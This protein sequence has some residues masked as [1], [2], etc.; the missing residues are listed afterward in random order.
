VY[1]NLKTNISFVDFIYLL[2]TETNIEPEELRI[3]I[4]LNKFSKFGKN[5]KLLNILEVF[6]RLATRKQIKVTDL[7]K[8]EINEILLEKYSNKKTEKL[9]KELDMIGY[10]KETTKHFK[11][12]EID[13]VKQIKFE[14]DKLGKAEYTNPKAPKNFYIVLDV[15]T[16]EY[17]GRATLRQICSGDEEK[18]IFKTKD[19]YKYEPFQ[20]YNRLL[21][22]KHKFVP[23]TLTIRGERV[24]SETLKEKELIKFETYPKQS[25]M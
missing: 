11:D 8:L 19:C 25:V 7:E 23:K 13:I 15:E 20:K 5:Q 24:K 4:K 21:I 9:Y 16:N 6:E 2:K 10:V 17:S 1:D 3:L 12:E 22:K 18:V 14:V